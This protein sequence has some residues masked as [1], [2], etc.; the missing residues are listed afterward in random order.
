MK[1]I[2][3][4]WLDPKDS[5]QWP[6]KK[7]EILSIIL[8]GLLLKKYNPLLHLELITDEFTY[9]SLADLY[10]MPFDSIKLTLNNYDNEFT[11]EI[12]A[13]KK[14]F[15]YGS[16]NERFL[17]VDA[18]VF[19]WSAF[20]T[21]L[22]EA[23]IIA[24][25]FER[26]FDFYGI[27][28]EEFKNHFGNIPWL[29]PLLDSTDA[30]CVGIIGG[31]PQ[32]FLN[33]Y[34]ELTEF[35]ENRHLRISSF[36][37]KDSLSIYLEQFTLF[38]FLIQKE[39]IIKTLLPDVGDPN[40]P[41]LVAFNFLPSFT[42]FIHPLG[43]TKR[44]TWIGEQIENR[45]RIDFPETYNHTL[46]EVQ[47]KFRDFGWRPSSINDTNEPIF[48]MPF[49]IDFISIFKRS[50][51]LLE[52]FRI[53]ERPSSKEDLQKIAEKITDNK[54]R[55]LLF[56]CIEYEFALNR[57]ITNCY[58]RK[59]PSWLSHTQAIDDFYFSTLGD[60]WND[61]FAVKLDT[62]RSLL[63]VSKWRWSIV[64]DYDLKNEKI[65]FI[66][67]NIGKIPSIFFALF[68]FDFEVDKIVET[69]LSLLEGHLFQIISDDFLTIDEIFNQ[70]KDF[71]SDQ[72]TGQGS[73]L[74]FK[75][76]IVERIRAWGISGKILLAKNE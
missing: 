71:F 47:A 39:V 6:N 74:I 26:S 13:L 15:V 73:E 50:W 8:S 62:S 43:K 76:K 41:G 36:K 42:N 37:Y 4:I 64:R 59:R 20:P 69:E 3:T 25:N 57:L 68:Y 40:Y 60:Y 35:L 48:E 18:D 45:L 1:I 10:K 19:K 53:S 30:F 22:L 52:K 49:S 14:L 65:D 33:F 46:K 17:N 2:Q 44:L 38:H 21:E 61:R 28:H 27:V 7:S 63:C 11:K 51:F 72:L 67:S 24:Q 66:E 70:I 9:K 55:T 58:S 75:A 54:K 32:P 31:N 56:D 29:P 5:N 16:Q 34:S 23:P 12:W